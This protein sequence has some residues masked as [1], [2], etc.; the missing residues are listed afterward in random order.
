[1]PGEKKIR[2]MLEPTKR[3]YIA[4]PVSARLIRPNEFS[5]SGESLP[6]VKNIFIHYTANPGTGA[7]QNRDYFDGLAESQITSASAHFV[8]GLEGEIVQCLPLDE[9]GYAV[10]GRNY[11][12]ISIECCYLDE[13][14]QFPDA[15]YQS[16]IELCAYLLGRY[17]LNEFD[18]MRHYDEGGKLCPKYYVEHP[19]AWDKLIYDVGQYIHDHGTKEKPEYASDGGII[20]SDPVSI[21]TDKGAAE[22]EENEQ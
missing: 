6:E 2:E 4:P 18:L 7:D 3:V 10:K 13:S 8:I 19:E 16:L 15:T 1:M 11:D 5:R 12:S 21:D 20:A 9:I 14:G 22:D 17:E